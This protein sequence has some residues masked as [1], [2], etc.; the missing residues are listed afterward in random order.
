MLAVL[1]DVKKLQLHTR[2]ADMTGTA[3]SMQ[4][5]MNPEACHEA[6]KV[7]LPDRNS[8]KDLHG[9]TEAGQASHTPAAYGIMNV[10]GGSFVV[11]LLDRPWKIW[12]D[13]GTKVIL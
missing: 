7:A 3:A 4:V 11:R 13:E 2:N 9:C 1:Q 6:T 12:G 5:P 8:S 10:D